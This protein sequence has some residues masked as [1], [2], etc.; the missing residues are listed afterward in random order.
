MATNLLEYSFYLEEQTL[1]SSISCGKPRKCNTITF[2]REYVEIM[3]NPYDCGCLIIGYAYDITKKF[4]DL[5][6][7]FMNENGYSK[8]IGTIAINVEYSDV[9][10]RKEE[11]TQL[12]Y[13]LIPTGQSSRHPDDDIE[14]YLIY[15]IINPT[16]KG[17]P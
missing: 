4:Q 10:K 3:E 7:Q 12:G 2:E 16:F 9:E 14:T 15:K 6:E 13:T 11:Y 17:Y 8:V 1:Q 5:L